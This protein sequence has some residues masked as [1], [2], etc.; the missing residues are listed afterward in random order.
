M[1]FL[2]LTRKDGNKYLFDIA[3]GWEIDDRGNDPAHWSN[4]IQ[5]RN[6]NVRETYQQIKN[7]IYDASK[8]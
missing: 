5:C 2:E 6:L 3:S 1:N 4:H 8:K 7:I